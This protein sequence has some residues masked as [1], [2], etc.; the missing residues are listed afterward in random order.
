V[1]ELFRRCTDD[2]GLRVYKTPVE[3]LR[4]VRDLSAN[5]VQ[6][7]KTNAARRGIGDATN[8]RLEEASSCRLKEVAISISWVM[9]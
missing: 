1:R 2:G 6:A 8:I 4:D 9:A 3:G 5:Q 7:D